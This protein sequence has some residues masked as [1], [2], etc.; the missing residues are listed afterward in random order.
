MREKDEHARNFL[1]RRE[2]MV[3]LGATGAA[4]LL[5]GS[6]A[7]A[8]R[9]AA[10]PRTLCIVHPEQ[11]EGPYFVDEQLHRSD[12]RSDPA[13]GR[14]SSGTPFALTIH[15]SRVQAGGCQPLPD[16]RVDVWHCDATGI[17][18]GV[19]DPGFNTVGKKF[20]RGYQMTDS[21][22]E[23]QFMTIYP[24]WYPIRTVHIHFKIR[25]ALVS[26]KR[27]EFTSQLYFPDKLTDHVHTGHPYAAMGPRKVRNRQDF[28]FRHGGDELMLDPSSMNDGYTAAF[29]I[30]LEI[31]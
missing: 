26:G 29:P 12:I 15:V 24:G 16:A 22:G 18:S 4:Y 6:Q 1:S 21:R 20:L 27:F 25:T 14:L 8:Q 2:V 7:V 17:Y 13:D 3:F 30:G 23:A 31:P 28:I 10:R 9:I 11:T 19:R 5:D